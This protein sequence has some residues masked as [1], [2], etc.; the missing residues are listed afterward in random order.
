MLSLKCDFRHSRCYYL[1]KN[2]SLSCELKANVTEHFEINFFVVF[3]FD[4]ARARAAPFVR[5]P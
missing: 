1:V 4:N 3:V 5:M 2:V